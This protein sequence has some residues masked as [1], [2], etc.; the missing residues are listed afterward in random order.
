MKWAVS[1]YRNRS[2][3]NAGMKSILNIFLWGNN[4]KNKRENIYGY[5]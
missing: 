3:L 2:A 5:S 4:H 1:A